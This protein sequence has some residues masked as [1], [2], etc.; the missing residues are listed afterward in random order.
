MRFA[1]SSAIGP[2]RPRW[3]IVVALC[4]LFSAAA[5]ANQ[6]NDAQPVTRT[7]DIPGLSTRAAHGTEAW[8][9]NFGYESDPGATVTPVDLADRATDNPVTTGTLPAGIAATPDGRMI[10]VADEGADLLTVLDADDGDV[11]AQIPTGVEPD[12]VG[13][14]PNGKV[15]LVANSD[16]GTVTPVDLTTLTAMRPVKV[17]PQPDAIAIG[18]PGGDVALVANLGGNSVTPVDLATMTPGSPISVGDEPD[19]IAISPDNDEAVVANLGSNSVSFVNLLTLLG[20][21]QVGI[22]VAPTGIATESNFDSEGALAWVSGG[23]S[24]VAVSFETMRAI[25]RTVAVGHLAE[26]LAIAGT[27]TTAWVADNDP[28]LTEIDLTDG[29]VLGS[30]QV[31]GRPSAVVIPPPYT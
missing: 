14:S 23:D 3:G 12:A 24:L 19:A 16:D 13:V 4:T 6:T 28:Y 5:C 29:T 22:G 18:G 20:G 17:G 11:L 2:V 27:G 7:A 8:V 26:A 31:G 9:C 1:Y 25:G 10:L 30:V 15:A 21:P